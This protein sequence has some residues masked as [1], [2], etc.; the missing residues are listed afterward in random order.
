MNALAEAEFVRDQVDR[1]VPLP[2]AIRELAG[3]M[4]AVQRRFRPE[5]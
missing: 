4:R 2:D 3:R 1:G 5:V